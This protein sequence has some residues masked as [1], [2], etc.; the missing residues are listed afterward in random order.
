MTTS[1]VR[2]LLLAMA[3]TIPILSVT[4]DGF[5]TPVE[6][7]EHFDCFGIANVFRAARRALVGDPTVWEIKHYQDDLVNFSTRGN[8]SLLEH[9][10]LA[11]AGL[12]VPEEVERGTVA[13]RRWFRDTALSRLGKIPNPYT[14]FPTFR[15]LSRSVNRLDFH[16]VNRTPEVSTVDFDLKRQPLRGTLR[17]D[18]I[19]GNEMAGFDT[20]AWDS[21]DDYKHARGIAG[22]MQLVRYGTTG[23]DRPTGCLRTG[24]DWE[25]WFKRFESARGRRIRTADSA[26]LTELVA[27]HKAGLVVVDRLAVRV[28]VAQKVGWLSSLGMG[29]FTRAQWDHMS[30]KVRRSTV[31]RDADMDAVRA[32]ADE[33]NRG[34]GYV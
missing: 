20:C 1:L 23:G 33:L 16:P 18:V 31:L 27:A 3:N 14:S 17:V 26:L 30:K 34:D 15:E 10:V 29:E 11:K 8:V 5:I 28:S 24:H 2:A 6:E 4:T 19:D 25:T 13:E 32:F 21:V 9:G 7:I 12:K 22:H